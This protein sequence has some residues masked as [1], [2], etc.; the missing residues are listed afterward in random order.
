MYVALNCTRNELGQEGL[1]GIIPFRVAKCGMPPTVLSWETEENV[2]GRWSWDADHTPEKE[3]DNDKKK[4][5][6][7]VTEV[8]VKAT[9]NNHYYEWS[10]KIFK[11]RKDS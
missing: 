8:L 3:V 6:A 1:A 9:L 10:G 5:P 11:Q 4:I 7:K 2:E